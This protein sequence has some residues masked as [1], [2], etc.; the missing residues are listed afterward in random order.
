MPDERLRLAAL[1][2]HGGPLD[3]RRH[4]PEEVVGEVLIGSDPDCHLAVDLPSISPIHARIWTDLDKLL[5]YD[6]RA[7]RGLWVNESRVEGQAPV[8]D[9]DVL[10]LGPPHDPESVCVKLVFEPWVEVLPGSPVNAETGGVPVEAYEAVVLTEGDQP[11]NPDGGE[12]EPAAPVAEAAP[13]SSGASETAADDPFFVGD[14]REISVPVSG[15]P[16]EPEVTEGGIAEEEPAPSTA[17]PPPS[18][19]AST[20]ED[21]WVIAEPQSVAGPPVSP[22]PEAEV[23]ASDD[24][25]FVAAEPLPSEPVLPRPTPAPERPSTP[26]PAAATE[27]H[28]A[29]ATEP[30]AAPPP[31]AAPTP[32]AEPPASAA[33]AQS[34]AAPAPAVSKPPGAPSPH[35]ERSHPDVPASPRPAVRPRPAASGRRPSARPTARRRPGGLPGWTRP[36]GLGVGGLVAVAALGF[37]ALRLLGDGVR[38]DTVEPARVRVGQR[39]TL[40]GSGFDV[41]PAGNTVLFGERPATVLQASPGRLEVEVP[42]VVSEVGA[43]R[44]VSVVVRRGR[45]ASRAVQVT[46]FQG[47]RLHGLSP[48]AAMPGEEVL[49][50]GTGWGL[51]AT[52]R[53][54]DTPAEIAEVDTARIRTIVPQVPGGPGTAAPVVVIVGGVESNSAPFVIG[55]LPVVTSLAPSSARPGEVVEVAGLGFDG[56]P[57]RNDV[58]V[59]GVPA[60]VISARREG[61]RVVVPWVGPGESS[62][63]LEVRRPGSPDVGQA[64]LQIAAAGDPVAFEFAAEPFTAVPGRPHAVLA[65][66]IG[67]VFVLAASGGRSAAERALETQGRLN[68]AG[69][70]LR[71]TLGLSLEARNLDSNPVIGL[72]GRPEVLIEVTA[73]DATAYNEDWSSLRGR[74][75]P[76]TPARLARWWEAVGRDLVL[77]TVRGERPHFAAALAPEGRALQQ[78]FAAAER[79]GRPGVPRQVVDEARPPLRDALRLVALRVPSSVAA[80][81]P[82]GA[83]AV[84]AAAATKTPPPARLQIEG[85]WSGTEVEQSDRRYVTVSFRRGGGTIAYEGG[86]TLTLPLL[87]F[88]QTRRDQVRFSVQVRGGVRQYSGQWDGEKLSGSITTDSAGKNVVAT[89]ELRPR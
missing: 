67:P 28:P 9:G 38:L 81:V 50:A 13:P 49:L 59:G 69:Q 80:L 24:A 65:T 5:A 17:T 71:T 58:R 52:V 7:P 57:L 77:L 1:I 60:L 44:S 33:P 79:T 84:A 89:F 55:H 82:G 66:G 19:P 8:G 39:A 70:P 46:A 15:A 29:A 22:P 51:G 85:T 53:F 30:P 32:A 73:E 41:D 16:A 88:E 63:V 47:P 43:D 20:E 25:F 3:G 26:L 83:G 36:V 21:E 42:E 27:R 86:I 75:G 48:E 74:G 45:Q 64:S 87:T 4:E 61:L 2:V 35:P 68:A 37:L 18:P 12:P 56:D 11:Q 10:W 40:T 54:G 76:V 23:P 62:R 6:T 31:P 14:G 34:V 72:T 78:L